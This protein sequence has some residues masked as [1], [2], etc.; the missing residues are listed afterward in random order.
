MHRNAASFR[1]AIQR[2]H[3]C[4]HSRIALQESEHGRD[5]ATCGVNAPVLLEKC[6]MR[7]EPRPQPT[8]SI[9]IESSI[10]VEHAR[11]VA[12]DRDSKVRIVQKRW[13]VPPVIRQKSQAT[14]GESLDQRLL[15]PLAW[16]AGLGILRPAI[17]KY[18]PKLMPE[19]VCELAPVAI[20]NGHHDPTGCRSTWMKPDR[21]IA[22]GLIIYPKLIGLA[23]REQSY[24]RQASRP[25]A[26]DDGRCVLRRRSA[27]SASEFQFGGEQC[28]TW[29][30]RTCCG[31]F[32]RHQ[33][34]ASKQRQQAPSLHENRW[35]V[36]FPSI[37]LARFGDG[38]FSIRSYK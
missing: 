10:S 23:V 34:A 12:F 22:A 3:I 14:Q 38:N 27:P 33:H 30:M 24:A 37:L 17:A 7:S 4:N 31:E 8:R 13:C 11:P 6:F 25:R 26:F 1:P 28:H 32:T 20:A 2:S 18:M 9:R 21:G 19:L 36:I 35:V 29:R 16:V 5:S 15:Y